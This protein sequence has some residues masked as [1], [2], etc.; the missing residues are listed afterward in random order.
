MT[1]AMH[2]FG[3]DAMDW[4][5]RL[6]V[7]SYLAGAAIVVGGAII[8]SAAALVDFVIWT[9]RTAETPGDVPG[10]DDDDTN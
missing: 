8:L 7:I 2:G 6:A 1:P 5:L 9:R 3:V 4:T 10:A